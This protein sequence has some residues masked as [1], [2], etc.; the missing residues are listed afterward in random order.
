MAEERTE[1]NGLQ[2]N[3]VKSKPPSQN[4]ITTGKKGGGRREGEWGEMWGK[5]EV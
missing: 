3:G 5:G 4:D 1:Y 2:F